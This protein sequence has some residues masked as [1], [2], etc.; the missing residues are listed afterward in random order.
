MDIHSIPVGTKFKYKG[1]DAQKMSPTR[2]KVKCIGKS[3]VYLSIDYTITS[4][5]NDNSRLVIV[6][7]KS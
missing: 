1:W 3:P 4:V 5:E 2:I 6:P 7:K